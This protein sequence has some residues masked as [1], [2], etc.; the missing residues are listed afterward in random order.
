MRRMLVGAGIAVLGL[1]LLIGLVPNVARH[2]DSSARTTNAVLVA[3]ARAAFDKYLSAHAPVLKVGPPNIVS[4]GVSSQPSANWSGYADVEN[5]SSQ[6]FSNVSGHWTIPQV[7]CL[8]SPYQDQDAFIAT[9]VGLDGYTDQTVEQLG[10]GADCYEGTTYYYVWYEMYPGSMVQE[11]TTACINSNVDCPQPGDQISASVTVQPA[12]S[13]EDNYQLTLTDSTTSYN[14][15]AV[16]QQCATNVCSDSSA[17][18]IVERPATASLGGQILPLVD[19]GRAGFT[20]AG[21]ATAGKL[22]SIGQFQGEVY[23]ISMVDDTN[24]YYLD[25]V[26]QKAPVGVLSTDPNACPTV[27]PI[28]S[29]PPNGNGP[30]NGGGFP[31]GNGPPNGGGFLNGGFPNGGSFTVTWDSSF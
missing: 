6:T 9:W 8:P 20:Q 13:G 15:F 4:G 10:T 11:G 12:T 22:K 31:N 26:G 27:A 18:W 28:G 14:S 30:P 24:S 25:C 7:T 21:A 16:S 23:D 1:S 17:E 19:F 2:A 3:Q 5:S 29:G